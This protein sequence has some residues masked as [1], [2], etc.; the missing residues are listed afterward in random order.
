MSCIFCHKYNKNSY[1]DACCGTCARSHGHGGHGPTCESNQNRNNNNNNNKC[2]TWGCNRTR[3]PGFDK[4]CRDC[5]HSNGSN[6]GR[7]CNQ[8]NNNNNN[9]HMNNTCDQCRNGFQHDSNTIYFY[10]LHKQ[11]GEFSNFYAPVNGILI[12]GIRYQTTEHYFQAQKFNDPQIKSAIINAKSPREVFNIAQNYKNSMINNW[13]Q[14][15]EDFMRKALIQ[16]FEQYPQLETL[17]VSTGNKTIVEH[18]VNDREWGDGGD[19][20]GNNKLGK[21]LMELRIY[22]QN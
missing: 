9:N 5:F 17:L 16:K 18:T 3:Y 1:G 10:H 21:L 13:H 19:G 6:H 14:I 4:C 12:D 22:Y 8:N 11:F 7:T 2:T 20:T 15:K